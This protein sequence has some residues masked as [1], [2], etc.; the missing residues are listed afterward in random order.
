MVILAVIF[1]HWF[2]DFVCQT[3]QMAE[4]KSKSLF[5]LIVH[6]LVYSA[7]LSICFGITYATINGLLHLLIDYFTSR[8]TSKLWAEQKV[9]TF[10]VVIG[11]DQALHMTCLMITLPYT[12]QWILNSKVVM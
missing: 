1:V 12:M 5:W 10:F 9:H 8:W 3:R 7:I 6:I 2:A 11:L 4:N